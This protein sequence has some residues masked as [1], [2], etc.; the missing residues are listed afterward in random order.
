[1]AVCLAEPDF[2]PDFAAEGVLVDESATTSL[3][4]AFETSTGSLRWGVAALLGATP[5]IGV[6]GTIG[7]AGVT[8]DEAVRLIGGVENS[9]NDLFA[10]G[11]EKPG[12]MVGVAR[13]G[14]SNIGGITGVAR[15]MGGSRSVSLTRASTFNV[16]SSSGLNIVSS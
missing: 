7:T 15:V 8:L 11:A 9:A 13:R 14:G 6:I 3:A 16:A 10:M 5:L 4:L 2:W 1:M 12:G